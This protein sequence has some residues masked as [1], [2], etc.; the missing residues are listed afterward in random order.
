MAQ[1]QPAIPQARKPAL[2]DSK[3]ITR[4]RAGNHERETWRN[5]RL[6][7]HRGRDDFGS[8]SGHWDEFS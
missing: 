3:T 1:S 5:M 6:S 4:S 8:F 7:A 2:T